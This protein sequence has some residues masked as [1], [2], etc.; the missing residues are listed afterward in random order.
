MNTISG[1]VGKRIK[2]LRKNKGMTQ[3]E[4]A[5]KLG[6]KANTITSYE[7]GVRVPS[8][9]VILSICR[10]FRVSESWLRTG[11]GEMFDP[12]PQAEIMDFIGQLMH[13]NED[14]FK[15][16]FIATLAKLR[17]DDWKV[18]E[19]IANELEKKEGDA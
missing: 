4:L 19:R 7:T 11:D 6:L 12:D 15:Q 8:D 18:L 14:S 1:D 2:I 10:M 9:S 5:E 17:E 3:L 16:R 13:D